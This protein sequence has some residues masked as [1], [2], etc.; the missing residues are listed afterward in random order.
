MLFSSLVSNVVKSDFLFSLIFTRE[1]KHLDNT[2]KD[3]EV[4]T[5]G[6]VGGGKGREEK[7]E[8]KEDKEGKGK[9]GEKR[10]AEEVKQQVELSSKTTQCNVG[11][12]EDEPNTKNCVS[13]D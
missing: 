4:K 12:G 6:I 7:E 1:R 8:T 3:K 5:E 11:K 2:K 13:L 10:G 9:G